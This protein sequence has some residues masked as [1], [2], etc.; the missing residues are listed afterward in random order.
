LQH[1]VW[2]AVVCGMVA[3]FAFGQSLPRLPVVIPHRPAAAV[4]AA[5]HANPT[6]PD[7]ASEAAQ[8]SPSTAATAR[9]SIDW[10]SLAVYAYAAIALAFLA[11]FMTGMFLVRKLL[12]GS[13]PVRNFLESE[14]VTVPLNVGWLR[15]SILLPL[16]WR[17]WDREK[18]D[19]VLA[20]E[21]AHARRRDGLV[22]ALAAVNRCLFWFH[23]L[24][25]ML[26]R[27]LALLA[28]QACDEACVA[29]LGDRRRY[30]HLLLEMALVVDGS[31]GRLRLHALTMA[32]GSHI[33]QRIDSLLEEGR[34]FSRGL[35]RTGWAAV[36]LCAIPVVWGAGAVELDRRPPAPHFEM[37]RPSVPAPPILPAPVQAAN[38]ALDVASVAPRE[39]PAAPAQSVAAAAPEFEAASMKAAAPTDRPS[40]R[41]GP[42]TASPGQW[43]C[44]AMPLRM[45]V[46]MAWNLRD[47]QLSGPS[48][49]DTALYDIAAKIP[50]G[51]SKENFNLMMQ[52]LLT[53]RLGLVV[54]HESKEEAVYNLVIAKGGLTQLPR[55]LKKVIDK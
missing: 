41:G 15:P 16:E 35:T 40:V 25:W 24:A 21:G 32:A 17:E 23:P 45:L 46:T 28:E 11:R 19:A 1:A 3:L 44:T 29:A 8:S 52:R 50:P 7:E 42:E 38:P 54:H 31:E 22:A 51:A 53:E 36:A 5:P 37:P 2:T 55:F 43:T 6:P 49:L 27:R 34:T 30:A 9:P 39:Q 33:R 4:P 48:S 13:H 26:E 14:S 20:H 18:L 12:A 47:Y 10:S